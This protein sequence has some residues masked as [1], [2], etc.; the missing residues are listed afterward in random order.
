MKQYRKNHASVPKIFMRHKEADAA[1]IIPGCY[2]RYYSKTYSFAY[3]TIS[4]LV[5]INA[6]R[7]YVLPEIDARY[8]AIQMGVQARHSCVLK[9]LPSKNIV[10]R[11][12]S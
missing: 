1:I 12:N 6:P 10:H 11:G 9:R 7:Y 4:T 2:H 5:L 3:V 8:L